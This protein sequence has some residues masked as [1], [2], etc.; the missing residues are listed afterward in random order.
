MAEFDHRNLSRREA[1][2]LRRLA[3]PEL[4]RQQGMLSTVTL[5]DPPEPGQRERPFV[6]WSASI[7]ALKSAISKLKR[8]EAS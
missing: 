8:I 5:N 3:E 2:I 1:G 6:R 7:E 4:L